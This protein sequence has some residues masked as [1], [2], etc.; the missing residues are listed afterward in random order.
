[1]IAYLQWHLF[2]FLVGKLLRY[3]CACVCT[4]VHTGREKQIKKHGA[5]QEME[6]KGREDTGWGDG[7]RERGDTHI[8]YYYMSQE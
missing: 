2:L 1:M 4:C 5:G 8:D 7:D 3:I 6:T